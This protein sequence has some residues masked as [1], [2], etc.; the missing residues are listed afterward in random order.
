MLHKEQIFGKTFCHIGQE[1][2][3]GLN[4]CKDKLRETF[5]D[6][7]QLVEHGLSLQ[8]VAGNRQGLFDLR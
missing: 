1:P 4:I 3:V 2:H 7:D 5:S 6:W 8:V